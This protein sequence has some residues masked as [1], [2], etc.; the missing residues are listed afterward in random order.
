MEPPRWKYRTLYTRPCPLYLPVK[1]RLRPGDI[2]I[3]EP[4]GSPRETRKEDAA[5]LVCFL[6]P[7][8]LLDYRPFLFVREREIE[9]HN[10]DDGGYFFQFWNWA[11]KDFILVATFK[12]SSPASVMK[13]C[14][15]ARY[16]P[17]EIVRSGLAVRLATSRVWANIGN[18][19]LIGTKVTRARA[20][21]PT[22]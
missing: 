11:E 6:S 7:G 19:S 22:L 2:S 8:Y 9:T 14:L 17:S 3:H 15:N 10:R 12:I 1:K 4:A 5:R 16:F 21:E 18:E 20:V 13:N